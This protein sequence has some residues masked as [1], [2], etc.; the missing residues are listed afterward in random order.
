MG[1]NG[2]VSL[3]DARV[4]YSTASV[5]DRTIP[6]ELTMKY[7]SFRADRPLSDVSHHASVPRCPSWGH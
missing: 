3:E 5:L 4:S 1:N 7:L 2:E 6:D